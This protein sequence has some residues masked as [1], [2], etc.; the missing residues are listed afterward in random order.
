[1]QS[2]IRMIFPPQCIS[3]G[4][5]VESEHQLCGACWRK[6]HFIS[7]LAC[8]ACGVPLPGDPSED[9]VHCDDCLRIARPWHQGRASFVYKDNGR[10]IVMALK[11]GDRLDLAKPAG[12]WLATAAAPMVSPDTIVVPVPAH[13]QRLLSRRYNQAAALANEMARNLDLKSIPDALVRP[14]RTKVHDGMG[15][16]ARFANMQGAIVP[17][18]KQKQHLAGC[19]VL[20]VDDVM[21]SGAT[22]AAATEACHAA[23]ASQVCVIALARVAKDA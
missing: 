17:N 16:D 21:T 10:W 6:T 5:L 1:M 22:F 19:S 3:C 9:P 13:W 12:R 7:G 20:L 4:D 18:P 2:V 15:R 14:S 8:D 23:G 11:H